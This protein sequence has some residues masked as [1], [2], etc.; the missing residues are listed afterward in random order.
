M[1]FCGRKVNVMACLRGWLFNGQKADMVA[2]LFFPWVS[3]NEF[4]RIV[5]INYILYLGV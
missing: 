2:T 3:M 4:N 1:L 5:E